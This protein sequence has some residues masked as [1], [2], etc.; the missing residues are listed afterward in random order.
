MMDKIQKTH[1]PSNSSNIIR[2]PFCQYVE[3][4]D[5]WGQS[6]TSAI[7]NNDYQPYK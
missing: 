6:L 1:E 3:Q 2:K 4:L 7:T 5:S